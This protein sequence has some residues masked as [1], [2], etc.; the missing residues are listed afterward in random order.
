MRTIEIISKK[1]GEKLGI[2]MAPG[3]IFFIVNEQD[4]D[5]MIFESQ[6]GVEFR[7]KELSTILKKKNR[8]FKRWFRE[9]KYEITPEGDELREQLKKLFDKICAE[10]K[11]YISNNYLLSYVR[12]L[13]LI[14]IAYRIK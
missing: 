13:N 5:D 14:K 12:L 3:T 1:I 11:E 6:Y 10:K 2:T 4:K 8:A 9:L 7:S